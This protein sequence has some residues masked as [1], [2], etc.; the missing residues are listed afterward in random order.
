MSLNS[1]SQD[2][3]G[4]TPTKPAHQDQAENKFKQ[5][6]VDVFG[7]TF[8]SVGSQVVLVLDRA[9]CQDQR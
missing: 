2:I 8:G 5:S 9:A 4:E 3:F 7:E 6:I 1:S